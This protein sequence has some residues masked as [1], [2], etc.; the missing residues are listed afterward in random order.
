MRITRLVVRLCFC[1]LVL[2]TAGCGGG[3]Q[4]RNTGPAQLFISPGEID[5]R[6]RILSQSVSTVATL[7]NSGGSVLTLS[8]VGISGTD[9]SD[10]VSNST[11]C[12]SS[13]IPDQ[14]CSVGV[15]FTPSQLGPRTASLDVGDDSAG[16]PH[17]ITVSGTGVVLGSN[18]TL[19]PPSLGF[20]NQDVGT[21]SSPQTITLTNYG[22]APLVISS[23]S[24]SSDFS[25]QDNCV[26]SLAPMA[27]CSMNVT[28]TPSTNSN[29]SGTITIIDDA[30]DS[31]QTASLDGSTGALKCVPYGWPCGSGSTCC[32][33]L[34]CV[35][36]G[37]S[38]RVGYSCR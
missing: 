36:T 38:T 35:F 27:S 4:P 37:G 6:A 20:G 12:G 31:P 10:F 29:V 23:I 25:E 32:A 34:K 21:T 14:I 8:S 18:V 26:T 5:F 30:P 33:G 24:P 17:S 2:V 15:T 28:F 9:S 11:A 22:T 13:L 7:K 1:V 19:S 3:G 16:G